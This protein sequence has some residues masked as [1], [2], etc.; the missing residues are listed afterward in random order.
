[1]SDKADGQDPVEVRPDGGAPSG[2]DERQAGATAQQ[3]LT[4]VPISNGETITT[5]FTLNGT[6]WFPFTITLGEPPCA[7]T[8]FA[9]GR[10]EGSIEA[11][12]TSLAANKSWGGDSTAKILLWLLLRQMEADKRFW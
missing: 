9:D 6:P 5:T 4:F 7:I 2:L 3:K 11:L 12:R 10:W 1:M 8:L